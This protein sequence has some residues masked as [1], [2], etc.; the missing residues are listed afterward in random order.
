ML[1]TGE[2]SGVVSWMPDG[3]EVKE[4]ISG[5]YTPQTETA[6]NGL[7]HTWEGLNS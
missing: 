5:K 3:D 6:M 4:R 7:S 2:F 1:R